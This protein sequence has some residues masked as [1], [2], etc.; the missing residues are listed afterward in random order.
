M[1]SKKD[2]GAQGSKSTIKKGAVISRRNNR[3]VDQSRA[4][5]EPKWKEQGG[6]VLVQVNGFSNPI[7]RSTENNKWESLSLKTDSQ[8]QAPTMVELVQGLPTMSQQAETEA[9]TR[10]L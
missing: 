4:H 5:S 10:L 8:P 9:L 1:S 2:S 7:H 6:G 3:T